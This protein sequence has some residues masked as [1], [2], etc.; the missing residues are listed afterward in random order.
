MGAILGAIMFGGV[1]GGGIGP[2]MVG[3]IY[4]FTK[5]YNLAFSILGILAIIGALLPFY[6]K[7]S[8]Q[9]PNLPTLSN[10]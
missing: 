4:D 9:Y 6:L 7:K 5:T 3:K 8:E 2:L 10:T 1:V